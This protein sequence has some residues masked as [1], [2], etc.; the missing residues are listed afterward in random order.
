MLKSQILRMYPTR[1]ALLKFRSFF[2]CLSVLSIFFSGYFLTYHLFFYQTNL[3]DISFKQNGEMIKFRYD[4]VAYF[5]GYKVPLHDDI[6]FRYFAPWVTSLSDK[7]LELFTNVENIQGAQRSHYD[8]GLIVTLGAK[9]DENKL[10]YKLDLNQESRFTIPLAPK[11]RSINEIRFRL[12]PDSCEDC[13]F[14]IAARIIRFD[15]LMYSAIFA[16]LAFSFYTAAA[17][18]ML[19]K[20]WPTFFI[21]IF[22]IVFSYFIH[23]GA[24]ISTEFFPGSHAKL[25][26]AARQLLHL[27][28]YGTL[29]ETHYRNL[30]TTLVP[31]LSLL[32]EAGTGALTK[33]FSSIYPTSKYIFYFCFL[34]S[35]VHLYS[36]LRDSF[37]SNKIPLSF[38]LLSLSFFPFIIDLYLP[39]SDAYFIPLFCFYFS[40][41]LRILYQ[42][43]NFSSH[44]L[45]MTV[46]I[47]LIG[48]I[49]V[50]PGFLIF[51]TP[52]AYIICISGKYPISQLTLRLGLGI[53]L[54]FLAFTVGRVVSNTYQHPNRHV[55]VPGERFQASVVWHMLWAASGVYDYD[56]AHNFVKA[57]GLRKK[58]V[59]EATGLPIKSYIHQSEKATDL[60]YKPGVKRA[61]RESPGFFYATAFL[62]AYNHGLKFFRYTYGGYQNELKPWLKDGYKKSLVISG[63]KVIGV[64]KERES[65]RYDQAWKISPLVF[66]A[67]ITQKDI[68]KII[69]LALLCIA[70]IGL[71]G[72]RNKGLQ[73]F[74]FSC[75][76]VQI[77]ASSLVHALNRYFMFIDIILLLGISIAIVNLIQ[78]ISTRVDVR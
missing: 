14:V 43:G 75:V 44:V 66:I 1:A 11:I 15:I 64:H 27:L 59:S 58:R 67:K 31:L 33:P 34:F 76:L 45:Y 2:I 12:A 73:F 56:S 77:G 57:G 28:N 13:G 39:D 55:G 6:Y 49:K 52:L 46:I 65:I 74:C 22:L 25:S 53:L 38:S 62:R 7:Q 24:F 36:S 70:I 18:S 35:V 71:F 61:L 37:N 8:N 19:R 47:F 16:L 54:L 4:G 69:D 51:I 63:T 40:F 29:G 41:F 72:I 50:T 20:S 26:G 5:E 30:G 21:P 17:Y 23:S 60:L 68:T 48:T 10:S 3:A 9:G 42:I 32:V 78:V